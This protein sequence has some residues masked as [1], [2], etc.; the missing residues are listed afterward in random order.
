M[1]VFDPAAHQRIFELDVGNGV[2][3]VGAAD[4][5]GAD[6]GEADVADM[7]RSDEIGDG[8]D[9]LLDRHRGI[10][11]GRAVDVDIV[12]AEAGERIGEEVAQC[13]G[14]GLDARQPPEGVRSAPNLSDITARAR[15]PPCSAWRS[16]SSL[17]PM[18]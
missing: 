16:K 8:A 2:D 11:A 7:A 14:A 18:P 17:C 13:H 12:G 15:L 1:A 6:L 3:G 10:E 5:L 4:G 9:G